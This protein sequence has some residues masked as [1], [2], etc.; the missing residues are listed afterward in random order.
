MDRLKNTDLL[1][2][3]SG[4]VFLSTYEAWQ[5]LIGQSVAQRIIV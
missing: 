1:A 5:R 2:N 3:L 4:E